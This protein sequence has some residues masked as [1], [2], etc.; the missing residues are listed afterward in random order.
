M[1]RTTRAFNKKPKQTRGPIPMCLIESG[2]IRQN[3]FKRQN[4]DYVFSNVNFLGGFVF[5]HSGYY[6]HRDQRVSRRIE[7]ESNQNSCATSRTLIADLSTL[8]CTQCKRYQ[9]HCMNAKIF[10]L[11]YFQHHDFWDFLHQKNISPM[12]NVPVVK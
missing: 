3:M 11:L 6:N 9:G 12:Q 2:S 7:R 1:S 10:E 4:L 8:R 5:L